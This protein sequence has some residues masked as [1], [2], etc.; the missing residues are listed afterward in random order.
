MSDFDPTRLST[1]RNEAATARGRLPEGF[2]LHHTYEIVRMIASGGMGDV[3]EAKH[4]LSE[5]RYAIKV[6]RDDLVDDERISGMFIR[7]S[8]ILK[9]I[10]HDAVVN[11]GG[12]LQ[13][14]QG[15]AFLVMD[16]IDGPSL[17]ERLR[18]KPLSA[19]EAK[20]LIRRLAPGLAEVHAAGTFHRDLSPDNILLADNDLDRAVIIDFGIAKLGEPDAKTFVGGDIAGKYGY[21]SPE[22]LGVIDSPVDGRSDIYSLGLVLAAALRGQPLEMGTNWAA[23]VEA[24]KKVPAL[25]DCPKAL[26]PLLAKML[27]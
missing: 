17:R 18:Q 13:D 27:A 24:R 26:R 21:I 16:Y 22:Q 11:Y 3:Y 12:L 9:R 25:N 7:E 4:L 6:I 20:R 5:D 10:R 19:D 23:V 14:E 15:R 1:G 8:D 2:V